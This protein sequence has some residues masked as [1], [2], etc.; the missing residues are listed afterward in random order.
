[1][2]VHTPAG[3]VY[4]YVCVDGQHHTHTREARTYVSQEFILH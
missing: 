1:M 2:D 3:M 4:R